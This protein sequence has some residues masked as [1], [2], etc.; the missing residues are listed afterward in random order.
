[1]PVATILF[2]IK[3]CSLRWWGKGTKKR[4]DLSQS[5]GE[6][7][8]I[9]TGCQS[10]ELPRNPYHAMSFSY[11]CWVSE[12]PGSIVHRKIY[13]QVYGWMIFDPTGTCWCVI[14]FPG[15][16][17]PAGEKAKQNKK[18]YDQ[19]KHWVLMGTQR[20][21]P[22]F[23]GEWNKNSELNHDKGLLTF[24]KHRNPSVKTCSFEASSG[25][26]LSMASVIASLRPHGLAWPGPR[27][28]MLWLS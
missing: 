27:L 2:S 20:K 11:S 12:G 24:G 9:R 19:R 4:W 14:S 21:V 26:T 23:T 17:S 13:S 15:S 7:G 10:W 25:L 8:F 18:S 22:S 5:W 1:M 6:V 16:R 3:C 28:L